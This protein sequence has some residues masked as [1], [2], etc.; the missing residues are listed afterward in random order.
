MRNMQS[1]ALNSNNLQ[2]F[3]IKIQYKTMK[4]IYK[5]VKFAREHK[6]LMSCEGF[7]K[8]YLEWLRT[9]ALDGECVKA[10]CRY[11]GVKYIKRPFLCLNCKSNVYIVNC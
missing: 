8:E 7:K 5:D 9:V 3:I 2:D 4:S 1:V 11:C 6:D 10:E